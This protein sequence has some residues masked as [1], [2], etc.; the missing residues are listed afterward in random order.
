MEYALTAITQS[1]SHPDRAHSPQ[2]QPK[3]LARCSPYRSGLRG[4]VITLAAMVRS[5]NFGQDNLT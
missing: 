3:Q 4:T 2:Y 5:H 1:H